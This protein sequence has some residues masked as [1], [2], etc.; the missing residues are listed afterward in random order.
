M[1]AANMSLGVNLLQQLSRQVAAFSTRI[2]IST[3]EMH[4]R[5]KVD[6]L[7]VQRRFGEAVAEGRGVDLAKVS[8]RVRDGLT[9][10]ARAANRFATLR[11]VM[12]WAIIL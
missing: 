1:Q 7:P 2:S 12:L 11:A 3:S 8:D 9:G 5:H 4:H 10:R 6:A